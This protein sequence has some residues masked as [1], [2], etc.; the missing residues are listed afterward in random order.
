MKKGLGNLTLSL[1]VFLVALLF[2]GVLASMVIK[3]LS[4]GEASLD[5]AIKCS[6]IKITP[7]SCSY[8]SDGK[9][10]YTL[11]ISA[12]REGRS[13]LIKELSVLLTESSSRD[14]KKKSTSKVP[15]VLETS[16]IFVLEGLPSRYY[17]GVAL[18]PVMQEGSTDIYCPIS[19]SVACI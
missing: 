17:S 3:S 15:S 14:V 2:V 13:E 7:T 10:K 11:R 4:A 19:Q 1:L 9:G 6:T 5:G 16:E 18:V 8:V 12:Y